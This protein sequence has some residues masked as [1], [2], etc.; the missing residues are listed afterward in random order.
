MKRHSAALVL[1]TLLLFGADSA[2][3]FEGTEEREPCT[4]HDPLRRP[5]F[6][7]THVHTAFSFDASA[8]GVRNTPR[9]AYRFARG[10]ER[11]LQPFDTGGE[12]LRRARLRR[13]LDFAMVSDHAGLLGELHICNTPGAEGHD[14]LVCRIY[15]RWPLL[16]YYLVN[17]RAF[18]T[19]HP[20]RYGFCGPGGVRCLEAAAIP[21]REIQRAAEAAYDRSAACAFTSFVGYEWTGGPDGN[22]IHRNVV[23]RNEVVPPS[24]T[25]YLDENTP[26]GLWRRLH[27]D[28]LDAADRCDVLTIPH[29]SNLSNG[30]LFLT[31]TADG[32]P[33]TRDDALERAFLEP[34]VEIMQHKGDSE[35]RLGGRA[36]AGPDELCSF[37]KLPFAKMDQQPLSFRWTAPAPNSFVREALAEGLVQE[38]KLGANPFKYGIVASTDSHLGTPGL[39]AED[40]FPGHAAGSAASAVGV[41]L[42]PDAPFFGPGG[43]AVLWAEE[44]SRDALFA[45]MR[46]REAY[47]TSGPR[48]IARFFGGWGY[49]DDMCDGDRFAQRGYEGGVPMG[50]DLPPAPA[51][52]SASTFAAAPA[53]TFAVW[54]LRDAGTT[55]HPGALLQRVQ[56]VKI[57]LENSAARERVYEIAGDPD[58]G[59]DVDLMTCE[60]RGPG[61][62]SL[63]AVW[64]DPDFDP[65][66]RSLYYT[67]IVE[68]P[69]CRWNRYVCNAHAVDC[70]RPSS[71]P[72]ELEPCCDP[73]VPQTIQERAWTSPIWYAPEAAPRPARFRP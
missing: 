65:S 3:S 61:F 14:S 13:P 70:S 32:L 19:S 8:L 49:R 25:S 40:A 9:D 63:C 34:L 71:V 1:F 27:R 59:A 41:P 38:Q 54:A 23:F 73:T 42:M 7:D 24:P 15:R 60:R 47:G 10:E 36:G 69:S 55:E 52:A 17:S 37:E 28:C 66:A 26:E 11:G 72:S 16:S 62:D 5:Y 18:N 46:R 33:I 31:E 67:R 43:L 57:W 56:I 6:G 22:M 50:G 68:N 12:A 45:A 48:L 29:N 4:E 21:W 2:Q 51:L 30:A 64:R 39:V 58:N 35:C 44:N 20:V 53:P